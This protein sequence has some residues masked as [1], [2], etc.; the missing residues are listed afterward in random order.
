ML[1]DG[2]IPFTS[3]AHFRSHDVLWQGQTKSNEG[4]LGPMHMEKGFH[5]VSEGD[6]AV[7]RALHT[8]HCFVTCDAVLM[9]FAVPKTT[10]NYFLR[11]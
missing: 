10:V 1:I 6:G 2:P 11:N 8:E 5:L 3:E 4:F 9:F 7:V